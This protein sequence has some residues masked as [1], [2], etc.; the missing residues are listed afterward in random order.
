MNAVNAGAR[1]ANAKVRSA[2]TAKRIAWS[3][4][5][6]STIRSAPVCP[7]FAQTS[8][9]MV[10]IVA[11][12]PRERRPRDPTPGLGEEE[13]HD[14]RADPRP[15]RHAE[16][17]RIGERIA[18]RG[19]EQRPRQR[20]VHSD[21]R[22]AGRAG[23][24]H[25]PE[26]AV[27]RMSGVLQGAEEVGDP[28][29]GRALTRRE[30]GRCD[31][32][33][34]EDEGPRERGLEDQRGAASDLPDEGVHVSGPAG[35]RAT[36][37]SAART[38]SRPGL[39]LKR[40][41]SRTWMPR[42]RAGE[43]R[44]GAAFGRPALEIRADPARI[45]VGD[46]QH[47]VGMRHG[48]RFVR[49]GDE[50]RK[51][52]VSRRRDREVE[53]DVAREVAEPGPLRHDVERA[54]GAEERDDG[55]LRPIGERPDSRADLRDPRFE[56]RGAADRRRQRIEGRERLGDAVGPERQDFRAELLDLGGEAGMDRAVDDDEVGM[57][58]DQALETRRMGI[59]EIDESGGK[60]LVERAAHAGDELRVLPGDGNGVRDP[61][62]QRGDPERPARRDIRPDAGLRRA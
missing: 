34:R 40:S 20:E 18:D 17:P 29:R 51:A 4:T 48:H 16:H 27:E 39:A 6:V 28:E 38:I 9:T 42:A 25:V 7:A 1:S 55:S 15:R 47:E 45:A 46:E 22:R 21:Q 59:A 19:L 10:P 23:K 35:T 62:Q 60:R 8:A 14:E 31:E 13:D 58:L 3:E 43:P 12:P 5:P 50:T 26:H 56:R 44:P 61:G 52:L 53:A 41:G 2:I 57:D 24:P 36:S 33:E 11:R 49:D 37:A 30:Q 54:G 32:T